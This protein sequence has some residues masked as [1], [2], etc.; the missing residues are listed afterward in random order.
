MKNIRLCLEITHRKFKKFCNISYGKDVEQIFHGS[1]IDG[2][3][4]SMFF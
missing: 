4:I 3:L 2:Y 1:V